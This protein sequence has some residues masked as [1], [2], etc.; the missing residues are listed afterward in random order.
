[1]FDYPVSESD[2]MQGSIREAVTFLN[3]QQRV[4]ITAHEKPDGD[5]LGASIAL[6]RI[7]RSQGKQVVLAGLS[8]LASRYHFLVREGEIDD[9]D[10]PEIADADA[11]I[12]LDCGDLERIGNSSLI[13]KLAARVPVLN[14]D[15]HIT[16]NH[17]G[18]VNWV[19]PEASSAGEMIYLLTREWGI[20][21][22]PEAAEPLWV[23]ITT[24]TGDFSF[25]NTTARVMRIGA[26]L[27]DLGVRPNLVR[28]E[29][30]ER[31]ALRELSL[32]GR[33]LEKL[34]VHPSGKIAYI[35]L[36][37]DDFAA[38]ECGPQDLHDPINLARAVDGVEIAVM[39][40]EVADENRVKVS[41]RTYPPHDAA[42]FC[43]SFGGGGHARAA[44]FSLNSTN[45]ETVLDKVLRELVRFMDA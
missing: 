22:P 3:E 15:H 14:I 5:A 45:P 40:Y 36:N 13:A 10:A 43:Q 31:Q 28:K 33:C 37:R 39:V 42:T 44:G 19:D 2:S 35:C 12:A 4:V 9:W 18:T 27:L 8:P 26:D 7:L 6:G 30:H 20:N 21:L 17:F 1:M 41:L 23:A 24:D 34:R 16:N 32:M 38:F 29:L 11:L 25:S